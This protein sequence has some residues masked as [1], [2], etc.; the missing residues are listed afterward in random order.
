MSTLRSGWPVLLEMGEILPGPPE[1][2]WH[3]I[4]DWEHQDAWMLEA[5]DF[6]VTSPHREGLGVEGEAAVRIGGI[7]TRDRVTVTGWEPNKR[8]AIEH[9]GWVSGKAE[10]ILTSLGPDRTH[11]FWREELAPP[12][13][14]LG[15]LGL[16]IF[17]PLMLRI[18]KRDLKV[19]VGLVRAA[20]SF[21]AKG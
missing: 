3:L 8:L 16:S 9:V 11:I 2:V 17:R 12:W 1:V 10:M 13:G 18:F 19:L 5:R 20:S 4:T 15:G 14:A 6:V 7:T 21:A